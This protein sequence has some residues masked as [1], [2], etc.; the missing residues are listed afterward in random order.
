MIRNCKVMLDMDLAEL[1]GVETG[2]LK[3]CCEEKQRKISRGL[4]VRIDNRGG[5]GTRYN[6]MTFTKQGVAM[7]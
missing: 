7:L 6:P 3:A 1:Y 5:G 4:Y 2:H